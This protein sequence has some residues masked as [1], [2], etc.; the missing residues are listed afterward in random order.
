M[1]TIM[2]LATVLLTIIS[3]TQQKAPSDIEQKIHRIG[4]GLTEFTTPL[5]MFQADGTR[6]RDFKTLSE[7][8]EHYHVPGV[9]I[10][11]IHQFALEWARPYGVLR[12]DGDEPVATDT[13]FQAASTSKLVAAAIVL[14]YVEKGIFRLDEDV[15]NYLKSW[16]IPENEFTRQQKVTLRLLLTHQSGLPAT[17]FIQQENAGDPTMVQVLKGELPAMNRPAV[18]EVIPGTKW[19][20]SNIGF[21]VIQQILEDVTGK[22]YNQIAQEAVFQPLGMKNSTFSYPLRQDLKSREAMPH[23]AD[24]S[25]REPSMPPTAL[26]QGGLVSTPSDLAIFAAELMRGYKGLSNR[27]LSKEMARQ[28]LHKELDL[29]PS[30]F[31]VPLSEGLG[32]ILRGEG[33]D[34]VFAAPGSNFPGMNCWLFGYPERGSGIVVMTNGAQGEVLAMEI[35]SAFNREYNQAN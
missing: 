27:L 13:Y 22:P 3:C 20:Y 21:V 28:I 10:A 32:V 9:S 7:R 23:D 24:G 18:V 31:G 34:L 30:M 11:V 25:I 6:S 2:A 8:M 14:H 1:R 35:I 16:R 17:D 4:N 12:A 5:D 33:E 15:N 29:D 26:A 19:Q